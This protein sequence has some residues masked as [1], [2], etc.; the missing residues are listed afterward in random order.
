MVTDEPDSVQL[1]GVT[2]MAS[3]SGLYNVAVNGPEVP[4]PS[5]LRAV[6]TVKA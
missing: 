5:S 6:V 1:L 4:D 2:S 3:P